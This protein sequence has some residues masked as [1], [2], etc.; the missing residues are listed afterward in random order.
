MAFRSALFRYNPP[1]Y[2]TLIA[3]L[4][5]LVVHCLSVVRY[6][7][8]LSSRR[9]NQTNQLPSIYNNNKKIS[10]GKPWFY[11]LA[12][13]LLFFG[14]LLSFGYE[15]YY[16]IAQCSVSSRYQAENLLLAST[17]YSILQEN[18]YCFWLDYGTMLAQQR[19]TIMNPWEHDSDFSLIHPDYYNPR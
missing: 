5:F 17:V 9:Q 11:R 1:A 14:T 13:Y 19:S 18:G 16:S 3:A 8:L 10:S 6:Y 4:L 12:L 7:S 15:Y 2:I